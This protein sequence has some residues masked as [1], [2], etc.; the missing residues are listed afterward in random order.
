MTTVE[1]R[2]GQCPATHFDYSPIRPV[3]A[4]RAKAQALRDDGTPLWV[5]TQSQG[6]WMVSDPELVKEVYMNY[7]LFRVDSVT[8]VDPDL[9][10]SQL[11]VPLNI[12]PPDHQKFRSL[13]NPWFS[14]ASVARREAVMRENLRNLVSGFSGLGRVEAAREYAAKV[15]VLNLLSFANMPIDLAE[16][17]IDL[18]DTFMAGFSGAETPVG[19][20]G[21]RPGMT[22]ATDEINALMGSVIADRRHNPLDPD[23]DLFT[24]LVQAEV[25]GRPLTN[26]ELTGIGLIYVVGGMETTRAQLGWLMYHMAKFP[27]DRRRV[28][29]DPAL[30]TPAIEECIRYYTVIWGVG[31]KVG[32]DTTWHGAD[33]RK[34]DM[35]YA[36]NSVFNCDTRRFAD[37]D[38]FILDRKPGPNLSFGRGPHSCI[39]M[40]LARTQLR[41]AFEEWHRQIP[42]YSIEEGAELFERGSEIT[43]QSL[44][45][46][47]QPA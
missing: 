32:L 12:N 45:L 1:Q 35:V 38:S 19:E 6:F 41:L 43:I 27:E 42:E 2:A 18:V 26:A 21:I 13:L 28:L 25:D 24:S 44:P 23:M 30:L 34:G 40:H 15:P 16:R 46:V 8:A 47:W 9:D 36:L 20:D 37:A 7:E 3:G 10:P 5:N 22:S 14:P 31:R 33:L 11:L 29:A 39:G 17:L 4:Y